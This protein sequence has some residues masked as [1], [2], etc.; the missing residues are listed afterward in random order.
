M[1][2]KMPPN[3]QH[4]IER[5]PLGSVGVSAITCAELSFGAEYSRDPARGH[6]T[7]AEFLAPLEQLDFPAD[8]AL[9]YSRIR[10]HLQRQGRMIGPLDLLI[11]SHAVHLKLCLVTNNMSE[12]SRIPE[13]NLENWTK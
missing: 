5:L 10:T 11:A 8:A 1:L 7:V 9:T 6:Q 12:Y 3:L 4:R 13:L 2:R